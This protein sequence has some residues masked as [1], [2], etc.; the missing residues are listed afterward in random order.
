MWPSYFDFVIAKMPELKRPLEGNHAFYVLME[1]TG[2]HPQ[3]HAQDFE[4]FLGGMLE[5]GIVSDAALASSESDALDFWAIRD[6]PGEYP[7]LL[8]GRTSFDVSFTVSQVGE[9]ASRCEV[10]LRTRWPEATVLIYGHLGDG[11]IHIV[12]HMPEMPP[13]KVKSIQEVVYNITGDLHGSVS[14]E[15]GI[16]LKKLAVI[17]K[18]RSV[19]YSGDR[20]RSFRS[21]VTGCAACKSCAAQIVL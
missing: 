21:I 17:G 6:A 15:H 14:A 10:A 9:A 12:V 16:G 20:D 11:N 8:P 5:Q 19:R 1:S 13:A 18:T 7:R 2:A 4:E 3:S